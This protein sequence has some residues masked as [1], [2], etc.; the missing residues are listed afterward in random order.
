MTQTLFYSFLRSGFSL[1]FPVV[2]RVLFE[3]TLRIAYSTPDDTSDPEYIGAKA[4]VF[5]FVAIA[6]AHMLEG[7]MY[8]DSDA[9]AKQGQ[10]LLSDCLEDA[11]ITTLQTVFM[12]VGDDVTPESFYSSF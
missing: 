5:V 1:V 9:C 8:V 4:C 10:L 2:D 12:L 3:D 11:S 6:S 7:S